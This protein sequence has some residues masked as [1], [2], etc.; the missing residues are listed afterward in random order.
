VIHARI[1]VY[2]KNSHNSGRLC[3]ILRNAGFR[4]VAAF[5]PAE[6]EIVAERENP[7]LLIAS[8]D[9]FPLPPG[10]AKL[11]SIISAPMGKFLEVGELARKHEAFCLTWPYEDNQVLERVRDVLAGRRA[12]AA[13]KKDTAG[14]MPE[15]AGKSEAVRQLRELIVIA[16]KVDSTVLLTGETGTGKELVA[17][18]LHRLGARAGKPFVALNC[19]ALAEGVLESELFG[20]ERGSFTGAVKRH[21]GKFESAHGGSLF[22]DEIGDMPQSI[23]VKLLRVLES[24]KFFPVGGNAEK[25]VDARII[26]ATNRDIFRMAEEEGFRRD[27]LYRI[28]VIAVKLPPLRERR[29]DIKLLAEIFLKEFAGKYG[30]KTDGFSPSALKTLMEHAWPGNVRELRHTIERAVVHCKGETIE[31]IRPGGLSRAL[32]VGAQTGQPDLDKLVKLD[33]SD[34]KKE[35]LGFYEKEYLDALLSLEGG[36]VQKVAERCG[37]DR[38]TL[39]R[40]MKDYGLDKKD[41]R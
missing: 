31:E 8:F 26:C 24:G 38:K 14:L 29:E 21:A 4:S 32:T 12:K 22:L 17:R 28:N 19:G 6:A 36:G 20:H 3:E 23:Q 16:A 40:K 1:L 33:F 41:Y 7:D 2:E 39:Y 9:L 5:Y 18:A 11:P 15:I 25:T 35:V 34:M 13:L 10:L 27:L 30:R 37:M